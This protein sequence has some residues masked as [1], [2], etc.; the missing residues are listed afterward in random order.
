MNQ[1][2]ME[3]CTSDD[4]RVILQELI[5][6]GALA[7]VDLGPRIVEVGPGPGF[8]TDILRQAAQHV[9]AVE[10]DSLLADSLRA[11]LRGSNV[12]VIVGDAKAT[13]LEAGSQTGAASFHMLHHIPTDGDQDQVF[14]ELFRLLCPKG[15]LLIADG[16]E[17]E[18][19]RSF[20]EGDIYNP[21]DLTT[22]P[23]RLE[24]AGFVEIELEHHDLGWYCSAT[25]A[26]Q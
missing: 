25:V 1:A 22:L 4:W 3:F 10:I 14:S 8:T 11:R 15:N 19:V 9:T 18:E 16:F 17:S 21:V 23:G 7:G 12:D 5:L 2:H 24:R 6:P 26:P 20:H 13:G